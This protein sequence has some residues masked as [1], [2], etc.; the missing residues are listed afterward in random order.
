VAKPAILISPRFQAALKNLNDAD[1]IRVE[2][3][4]RTV[5]RKS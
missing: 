5:I 3:A 4:I 1:L 2:E